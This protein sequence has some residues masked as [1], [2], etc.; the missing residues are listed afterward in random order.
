M[1]KLPPRDKPLA[2]PM[3]VVYIGPNEE[4]TIENLKH[5]YLTIRGEEEA[6]KMLHLLVPGSH[7]IALHRGHLAPRDREGNPTTFHK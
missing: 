2:V 6:V 7:M 3:T 5:L 4:T 1:N